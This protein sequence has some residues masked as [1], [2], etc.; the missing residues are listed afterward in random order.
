MTTSLP[1]LI[2]FDIDGTLLLSDGSGRAAVEVALRDVFNYTGDQTRRLRFAGNTDRQILLETLVPF[3]YTPEAII[4][5]LPEF[6]RVMAEA[7]ETIICEHHVY[8]LPGALELVARLTQDPRARL[9]LLTG[10]LAATAPIKLRAAGFN[11]DDFPIGAFG[12]EAADR[13]DL[14]PLAV[15]RAEA[16]WGETFPPERIVIV[17]DT[18]NDVI[19]ARSVRARTLAVLTGP[20]SHREKIAAELPDV[21]LADL[22]D[23]AAVEAALFGGSTS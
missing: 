20:S 11:P 5:R 22:T 12:H 9:G 16:H 14:P 19:C 1:T 23:H 15:Q 21:I 3:G 2:L 17:G 7:L 13:S 10:N 4:A 8:P 6:S 18:P